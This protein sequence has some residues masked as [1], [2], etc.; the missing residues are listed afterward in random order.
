MQASKDQLIAELAAAGAV[1][2]A[3]SMFEYAVDKHKDLLCVC[4]V[5]HPVRYTFKQLDEA[6]NRI[7]WWGLS[8][9]LK[10]LQTVALLMENRPEYLA[11]TMGFAKIGVTI[12]LINTNLTTQL[13]HHAISVSAAEVVIVS[14]A[15]M[16]NWLS[17]CGEASFVSEPQK[18]TEPSSLETLGWFDRP[19]HVYCF[20]GDG[21]SPQPALPIPGTRTLVATNPTYSYLSPDILNTFG[22]SRPDPTTSRNMVTAR[23]P[24]YYIYTSG[25]TGSSKAARFSHRRFVGAA[26]TWATPSRLNRGDA[27]YVALP[28]Y[29]GNAGVVAVAPSYL[30]GN[31]I[32]L[33][34]R[35]SVINFFKDIRQFGCVAT[36][37]IGELWRYLLT[38]PETERTDVAINDHDGALDS[39]T[40]PFSPLRIAIG[41]GLGEEVWKCIKARFGITHVVEHYGSTEMPGDAVLNYMGKPGSCGYVPRE[42]SIM[43]SKR[44][45]GGVIVRYDVESESVVR[46]SDGLCVV[47]EAGE[48]G[49]MIMCLPGGEYDG[50][51]SEGDTQRKLYRGVFEAEDSW[52]RSGDLLRMDAEGF[53]YFI[54]RTGDSFRWKGENVS[55]IDVQR[56]LVSF[57]GICEANA[58]GVKI[59]HSDG[60]AGMV[61]LVLAEGTTRHSFRFD[62]LTLHLQKHLPVYARPLFVRLREGVHVTTSTLKFVKYVYVQEGYRMAAESTDVVYVYRNGAKIWELVDEMVADRIDVEGI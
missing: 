11:M 16:D 29:H 5:D 21:E 45:D 17:C 61:S 62:A 55:T 33:R 26:V 31:V 34:E 38:L 41:N 57:P 6:A 1:Q 12:A 46:G 44:G 30:L 18:T 40:H 52:W 9:G 19:I 53:F 32:V 2:N 28:L 54:D 37:Y 22:S 56:A 10:Q 39:S 14:S 24:L 23:M 58:Y 60:R 51:V 42:V 3:A 36:I 7:A 47:C 25:T 43:K 48:V 50:Y 27:Y 4:A 35:F 49:E 13:L 15:K 59:P 20:T 8:I